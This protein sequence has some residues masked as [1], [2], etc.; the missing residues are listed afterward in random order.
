[1]FTVKTKWFFLFVGWLVCFNLSPAHLA[2]LYQQSQIPSNKETYLPGCIIERL[3]HQEF[4]W[5]FKKLC[6]SFV[7]L[8]YA[9][10]RG[11]K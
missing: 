7:P 3:C 11:L 1:M 9:S 8:G 6:P 4:Y 2:C 10:W 5:L